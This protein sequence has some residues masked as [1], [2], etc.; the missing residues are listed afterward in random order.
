[1]SSGS[2][3]V[4]STSLPV[5]GCRNRSRWAWSAWRSIRV[6]SASPGASDF[7]SFGADHVTQG[8]VIPSRIHLVGQDGMADVSEMDA[9]LVGSAGLRFAPD[10]GEIA[11]PLEDFV[12]R[13]RGLAAVLEGANGH[14]L[15]DGRMEADAPIDVIAVA[16]R[17]AVDQREILL[18]H[19]AQLE[20]ERQASMGQVILGDHE[21]PRRVA[22][23]T[24]DDP[25][26]FSPARVESVSKW[27]CS[28]VDQGAAPVPLRRMRDHARGLVHHRQGLVLVDDLDRDV[29][30]RG[31]HIGQFGEMDADLIAGPHPVRRLD[32]PPVDQ[33]GLGVDHPL[34]HGTGIVGEAARQVGVNPLAVRP[35]LDLEFL[36]RFGERRRPHGSHLTAEIETGTRG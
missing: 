11:E 7:P 12:E 26:R 5:S 23:E 2:G 17:D 20:L 1:M 14:L 36:R 24:V 21:Q 9:N 22:V 10:Q 25:G 31:G 19:F 15:A 30:R 29:F 34:D 33:H 28:A 16:L 27:N 3:A 35:R 4:R 6:T 32:R 18:V 8:D 13:H